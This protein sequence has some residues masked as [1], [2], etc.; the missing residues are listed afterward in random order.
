VVA[1]HHNHRIPQNADQPARSPTLPHLPACLLI[2]VPAGPL[3]YR[4]LSAIPGLFDRSV[5]AAAAAELGLVV[6]DNPLP[7]G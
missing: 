1:D 2:H 4:R 5:A 6:A 7:V 3:P